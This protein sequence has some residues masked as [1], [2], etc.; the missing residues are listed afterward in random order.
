MHTVNADDQI[1]I[2]YSTDE[3]LTN[4]YF[5]FPENLGMPLFPT[6]NR[7][8]ALSGAEPINIHVMSD[9]QLEG[10]AIRG[11]ATARRPA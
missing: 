5:E 2:D 9:V 1:R 8:H 7:K 11:S 10:V 3:S 6:G 4:R